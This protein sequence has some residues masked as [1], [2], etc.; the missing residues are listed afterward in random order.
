M[1][2]RYREWCPFAYRQQVILRRVADALGYEA[3]RPAVG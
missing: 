2:E 1:Y 3:P